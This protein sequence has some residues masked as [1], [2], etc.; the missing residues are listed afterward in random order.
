MHMHGGSELETLY[1]D[2]A[3]ILKRPFVELAGTLPRA[4][5]EQK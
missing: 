4:M 1:A 5:T 2:G 3:A